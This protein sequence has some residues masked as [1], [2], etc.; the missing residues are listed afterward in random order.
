VIDGSQS[1][2]LLNVA[3]SPAT[4]SPVRFEAPANFCVVTPSMFR[5]SRVAVM[6]LVM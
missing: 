6:F 3:A 2:R 1:G 4:T 5:A